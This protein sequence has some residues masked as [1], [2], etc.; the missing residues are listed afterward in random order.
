[1]RRLAVASLLLSLVAAAPLLAQDPPPPEQE[2]PAQGAPEQPPAQ[3]AAPVGPEGLE[4]VSWFP[5]QV[6]RR[7]QYRVTFSIEST[8]GETHDSGQ[9]THALDVYVAEPQVID[10]RLAAVL[11]WKLDGDLAQR[12]YFVTREGV[13]YCVKRIQGYGEHMKEF[14]LAEAQPTAREDLAV[15][16]E[17]V[18]QGKAGPTPG[19]QTFKVVREEEVVTPAGTFRALVMQIEFEGEDESRGTTTRWLVKGTGIVREVSEVR[20]AT[21]VF[22]TEGILVKA[23]GGK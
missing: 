16:N 1:V 13:L 11:E 19:R 18:W 2:T 6:N 10:G 4:G 7:W 5:L 3:P 15:G 9:A 17:W 23:E 20:T 8:A 22:R 21:S 12:C 14:L